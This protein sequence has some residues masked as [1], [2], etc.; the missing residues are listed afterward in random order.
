MRQS[1]DFGGYPTYTEYLQGKHWKGL[2]KALCLKPESRCY[3][4]DTSHHL[5]I[6]HTCYD[7]VGSERSDDLA[8]L[9]ADCHK[10]MHERLEQIYPGRSTAYQVQWTATIFPVLFEGRELQAERKRNHQEQLM[11]TLVRRKKRKKD[12]RGR[13]AKKAA[14][15]RYATLPVNF[16]RSKIK[17]RRKKKPGHMKPLSKV[18]SNTFKAKQPDVRTPRLQPRPEDTIPSVL[19]KM[20]GLR[21]SRG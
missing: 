1:H 19:S 13:K 17:K 16:E 14:A 20:F 21:E 18:I 5:Q 9:C 3:G 7:R 4:C 8:V 2:R 6:H 15:G 10:H 12:R 11:G